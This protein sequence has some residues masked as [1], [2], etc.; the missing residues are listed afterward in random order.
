V[1]L[2]A[3]ITNLLEGGGLIL[4]LNTKAQAAYFLMSGSKIYTR[5]GRNLEL[6]VEFLDRKQ[7]NFVEQ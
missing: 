6:R 3:Q 4:I 7:N 5:I 1:K 2:A